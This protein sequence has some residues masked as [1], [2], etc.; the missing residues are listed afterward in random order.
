MPPRKAPPTPRS[1]ELSSSD[2]QLSIP[3][4]EGRVREL[5]DLDVKSLADGNDPKLVAIGKAID[6]TLAEVFG[7]ET[8]QYKSYSDACDLDKTVYSLIIGDYNSGPSQQEIHAGIEEGRQNSIALL[9]QAIAQL[10]ERLGPV[11][12]T[13]EERAL[14]A[15]SD[16][17]LHKEIANAASD[18]YRNRH[19]ANAVEDSVKA[20]NGL[21]RLRSGLELDGSALMHK[22]F[23]QNAP[24]LRF[25]DL[26]DPSDRDE[27]QGFMMLFAGA[28]AGLRNPRAHKLI[29]PAFPG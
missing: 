16:L 20:L 17:D 21:V 7:P 10:K 4:L 12:A 13:P 26:A 23:S 11:G 19:Y 9:E 22:V 24:I 27:Q 8:H 14:R 3:R 2:I 25:N 29:K 6:I 18:L 1:A 5:R 28:V 15:Y